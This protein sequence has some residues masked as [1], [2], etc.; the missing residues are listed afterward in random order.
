MTGRAGCADKNDNFLLACDS[1]KRALVRIRNSNDVL[2]KVHVI[3]LHVES[4]LYTI[5]LLVCLRVV[6]VIELLT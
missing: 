1:D 2:Q 3:K 4:L 6:Q 5:V